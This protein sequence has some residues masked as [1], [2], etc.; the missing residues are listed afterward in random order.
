MMN[1]N[2]SMEDVVSKGLR[3]IYVLTGVL[4]FILLTLALLGNIETVSVSNGFTESDGSN[5]EVQHEYGGR[6]TSIF[7][8]NEQRVEKGGKLFSLNSD[9]L[10][11]RHNS[12]S[13]Q[14]EAISA[15]E[16]RLDA[17][18]NGFSPTWSTTS[19]AV[20]LEQKLYS[21]RIEVY[22]TTV[23]SLIANTG[24]ISARIKGSSKL[25]SIIKKQVG[26]LRKDEDAISQ[27][28]SKGRSSE[29]SLREVTRLRL[30][31]EE[32]LLREQSNRADME[33]RLSQ[34]KVESST[35]K[36]TYF[37]DLI[38]VK[39][40]TLKELSTVIKEL[41]LINNARSN[42]TVTSPVTGFVV[43]SHLTSIGQVVESGATV[44][45]IVPESD[46]IVVRSKL[47]VTDRE[48]VEVGDEA[49]LRVI[50]ASRNQIRVYEGTV[51]GLSSDKLVT[52]DGG[53]YFLMELSF[54]D[55]S[56]NV[57]SGLP[58][59]VLVKTGEVNIFS[60][61]VGPLINNLDNAFIG[62]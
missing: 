37:N 35:Y 40:D 62:K 53:P 52:S 19:D 36:S 11:V 60:Y 38:T 59:E 21:G 13:S 41:G 4:F 20:E 3:S 5:K 61:M 15:K 7:V 12:M 45:T 57:R 32:E 18:I 14:L 56:N 43:N 9:D 23:D 22:L 34:S 33:L 10:D 28:V 2:L 16:I 42:L 24:N 25:I 50:L 54:N 44:M 47:S 6:L 46:S 51:I 48:L 26:L 1:K 17:E 29:H 39:R 8:T 31:K 30:T 49:S 55:V 27:L 58:V